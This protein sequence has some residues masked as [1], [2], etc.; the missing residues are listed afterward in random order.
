[1]LDDLEGQVDTA[2]DHVKNVNVKMKE[3]LGK[4]RRGNPWGIRCLF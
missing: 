2:G 3:T 4:V 1:M